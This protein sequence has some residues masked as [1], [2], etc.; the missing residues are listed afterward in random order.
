MRVVRYLSLLAVL[1]A[2]LSCQADVPPGLP[3]NGGTGGNPPGGPGTG[4]KQIQVGDNFYSPSSLT[5]H[6]GD[7]VSWSWTGSSQH[8]VTFT[9]T[10]PIID[11]GVQGHGGSF[12]YTFVQTGIYSYYCKIH[13]ANVMSGTITVQ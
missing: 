3:G 13:G 2:A 1:G 5:V 7:S 9:T 10:N 4:I 6:P 11:S 8:S 12:T